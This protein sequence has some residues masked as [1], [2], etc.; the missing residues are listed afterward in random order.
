MAP[1][2]YVN[3]A[4][5]ST[6]ETLNRDY[7]KCVIKKANPVAIIAPHG[8][9]I[10]LGTSEIVKAIAGEKYSS[11][12]FEGIKSKGNSILHITSTNFDEPDCVQIISDC[13]VVVAIHGCKGNDNTVYLGGLDDKLRGA[14]ERELNAAGFKT[15]RHPNDKL[16]GTSSNNICN[17]GALKKG[18]Q[19]ELSRNLRD[20]ICSPNGKEKLKNF[21][22][23]VSRAIDEQLA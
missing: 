15:G 8:G 20:E 23:A 18:V 7:K 2:R 4:K 6:N 5:L 1:D 11:Y 13:K 9:K 3:F 14:I 22:A 12:C 16:Q 19:L 17:R 10:E 21:S